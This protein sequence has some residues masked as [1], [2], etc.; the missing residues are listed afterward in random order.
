MQFQE[1][2][3]KF[4]I[5]KTS[6]KLPR[7]N[8][9]EL[10]KKL[11][12]GKAI[13]FTGAGFSNF[14]KNVSQKEPPMAKQL[15]KE[16]CNL[17]GFPEDEDLQYAADYYLTNCDKG[18][19]VE[20]LKQ[21]Y[22]LQRTS[23]TH[24]AIC[25]V[26][27]RRFY[28]TN[29]DKSVEISS[30][31]T[32]KVVE[33][34]DIN[35]PTNSYYKRDQLCIHLNGSV[36]SL[37]EDSLDSSFK[38]ST[39]S[40][41]SPSSFIE[42]DW[43]YYF[44][45]DLE[46]SSAIVFAGYSM[47]DIEIQK[48]LFENP[49]LQEKT[50]F[51]TS[52]EPSSKAKFLLSKFGNILPIGIDG[53]AELI[54][55]N[56]TMLTKN[57][58]EHTLQSLALYEIS[59]SNQE[60]KDS[61]VESMLMYGD[62]FNHF[63]DDGITNKQKVPYLIIREQLDVIKAFLNND[64]NVIIYGNLGNGKSILLRELQSLL[65]ISSIESYHIVDWEGDYI[66]DIDLLAKSGKKIV[67][68]IDGYGRYID[69]ITHYCKSMPSNI[70]LVITERTAEHE[71]F[72]QELKS[73]DFKYN[74]IC[75]DKLSEPEM[76]HLVD[77]ID[78]L[79]MWGRKAGL[80]K[81]RKINFISQTNASELSL[82]LLSFF[83]APQINE[84]ISVCFKQLMKDTE[85]KDTIFSI[86]LIGVLGIRCNSSLIS[87]VANNSTI[88]K[89]DLLQDKNFR[90]LFQISPLEVH[91]K[92]SLFCLYLIKNHFS[93]SYVTKQLQKVAEIFNVKKKDLDQ[94]DIFKSTLRFSFVERL[95][96]EE[97]KKNNLTNYYEN[98]KISVPW[99]KNDPH[100]WLQYGM[101]KI[102]FKEYEKAQQ[103][104]DQ[105]Y[106]IAASK[107][108]YYTSNIDTQ[109][110]RLFILVA[111][112]QSDSSAMYKEFSNAHSLLDKL[113]ND[114]YKFR[115]VEKYRDYYDSCY[116][117]LSKG[118]KVRFQHA[119]KKMKGEID[120]SVDSGDIDLSQQASIQKAK[121][122]LNYILNAIQSKS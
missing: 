35:F 9:D 46:R 120:N 40:Y 17:G 56:K 108:G 68:T 66:G 41:I 117:I 10:L 21:K 27:W 103:Y 3:L 82:S 12:T 5:D 58:V 54:E 91:T 71:R 114:I 73:I 69:L 75:I 51:I 43:Y 26:N 29:Y 4:F 98:L 109:Q 15:A 106:A 107:E 47:Y 63:I 86:S 87:D 88:Y 36:D 50:Y 61:D 18:K 89:S 19:L 111:M 44:K 113:D 52:K 81:D 2:S 32:G 34:I 65:S 99:L 25:T 100:F 115:Q 31:N 67:I 59:D 11:S 122:N 1:A 42:S 110:A 53:F 90:T 22:T 72:R 102:T 78:N 95:L 13:L 112:N 16:I 6:L 49:V 38:L 74:E 55:T 33:C 93:S 92:S 62:I 14:T 45:K 23:Q 84:R 83:N 121:V 24:D 57:I 30:A 85:I 116:S 80:S 118:N 119:C 79:G 39:S 37:N 104:F 60:I 105:S 64:Q 70:N 76:P 101:A 94:K 7:V 20:S 96:S 8:T 77:I 48:I 97:N 28:T